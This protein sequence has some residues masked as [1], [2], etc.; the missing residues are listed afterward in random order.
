MQ[1]AR[2]ALQS[3]QASNGA[4]AAARSA[5]LPVSTRLLAAQRVCPPTIPR[6]DRWLAI[7][8][9]F[10]YAHTNAPAIANAL[11]CR[12]MLPARRVAR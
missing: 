7:L 12:R 3:R 2:L 10:F 8:S 9:P 5:R 6:A 11:R 4:R 1:I